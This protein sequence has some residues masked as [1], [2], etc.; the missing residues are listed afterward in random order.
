M[1][2]MLDNNQKSVHT[3]F[4][5]G[6][7]LNNQKNVEQVID[8]T[9]FYR[10][11]L[12]AFVEHYLN[13]TLHFYQVICLY[14]LNIFGSLAIIASRASAKSFMIAVFACA[15]AIL[16]P[17]SL[18]V[19]ASA[20][21]KQASLI[22][23]EKIEKILM[24][25]SPNLRREI[26]KIITN[27]NHTEVLFKNGSSI[28]VVVGDDRAR[29]YRSTMLIFEEFR[30]IKKS[31]VDS[32]LIPFQMIRDCPFKRLPDYI[33]NDSLDEEPVSAYISSSGTTS[34]WMWQ[35]SKDFMKEHYEQGT[36]AVLCMD[37]A[38]A[39]KH[40]IKS[41]KTLKSD[42]MKVDPITWR[43][44]YE[45]EMLRENLNSFFT[46]DMLA[47]NQIEKNCF[48]PRKLYDV[49]N[50]RKNPY[51][52]PKQ[53]NEIRILSCD[54][55]F[56][57]KKNNDNSVFTCIRLLPESVEYKSNQVDGVVRELKQGYRR[58]VPYIE[59]NKGTDIDKQAIRIKQLFT[60]F[61]ADYLVL[62]TRNGGI[63]LADRLAKVLYD[64]ERDVEYPAWSCMNDESITRVK[65]AGALPILYAIN[66]TLKLN[67]DIAIAM[68][69][70]LTSKRINLLINYNI[71]QDELLP[72]IDEYVNAPDAETL[73]FYENPY[74]QTQAL[75]SEMV[76]LEYEKGTQTGVFK[77][78]E[79]G[80]N[81][82]D[83]YTSL[84]YG[85]YFASLL[86]QDLLSSNEQ[87]DY[88][89]LVN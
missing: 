42:K 3:K 43:I 40:R 30:Q 83:R 24:K 76:S 9:T 15:K 64:E 61:Q 74:L 88:A 67:S 28:T 39:L 45:N 53:T 52:I 5:N 29:G 71:A 16:Y 49:I 47:K 25:T 75:I 82:K 65:V 20:T 17:G 8:W 69:E 4:Q 26:K 41:K 1:M 6:T 14:L 48:Y 10:R 81:T 77:I 46:Y 11:N 31:V 87:Y 19:I 72:K 84:S 21:K 2:T 12:P 27:G 79:K 70:V 66:A 23:S 32:V 44:E 22:V 58:I 59:V 78:H 63:L 60:D 13:I 33:D 85:N 57:D 37:Y 34:D 89:V 68:Q 54:I 38:I 18:I 7:W 62:D 86:E 35:L 51:N 55:A 56:V 50:G 80:T 36:A 73:T